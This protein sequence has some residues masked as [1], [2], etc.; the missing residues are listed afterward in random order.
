MGLNF[1]DII[2]TPAYLLQSIFRRIC[3][4]FTYTTSN[5]K[6]KKKKKVDWATMWF[7]KLSINIEVQEKINIGYLNNVTY[8]KF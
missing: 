8:T 4:N 5:E 7:N 6:R 1:M 2:Y 3:F